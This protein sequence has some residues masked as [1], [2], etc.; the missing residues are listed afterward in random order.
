MCSLTKA[1]MRHEQTR[2]TYACNSVQL[3]CNRLNHVKPW[4][5]AKWHLTFHFTPWSQRPPNTTKIHKSY[6]DLSERHLL[7]M[8]CYPWCKST[9]TWHSDAT[10]W[11]SGNT[12]CLQLQNYEWNE[13]ASKMFIACLT[14]ES[15]SLAQ[16]HRN[17]ADKSKDDCK[18]HNLW[19]TMRKQASAK[20][21]SPYSHRH[22]QKPL[23][24]SALCVRI[25]WNTSGLVGHCWHMHFNQ[26]L[27]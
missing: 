17:K 14:Q 21:K 12:R 24:S 2:W 10:K 3:L 26:H 25:L 9:L 13:K 27:L 18:N 6:N 23:F 1:W 15:G 19:L 7:K 20:I 16:H 11:C 4:A 8:V 22:I 5:N